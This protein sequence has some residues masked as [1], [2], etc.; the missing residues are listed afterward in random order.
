MP[1]PVSRKDL[2]ELPLKG[3]P[4]FCQGIYLAEIILAGKARKEPSQT[5]RRTSQI[6]G[7]SYDLNNATTVWNK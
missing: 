4:I 6:V 5:Q 7:E 1:V 3:I 2:I